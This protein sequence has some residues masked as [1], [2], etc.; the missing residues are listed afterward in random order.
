MKI[1][2]ELRHLDGIKGNFML[3]E[4]E[5]LAP[6]I[7]YRKGEIASEIVYS[8]IKELIEHQQYVFDTLWNKSIAAGKRE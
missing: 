5:Y 2:G 6:L 1:V 4:R 7:L 8:N 3:S